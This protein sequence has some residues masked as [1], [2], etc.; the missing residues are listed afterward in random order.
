MP[1]FNWPPQTI[2][3]DRLARV[4]LVDD[5]E[6]DLKLTEMWLLRDRVDLVLHTYSSP[7]TALRDLAG[8]TF[9]RLPDIMMID[10]NMPEMMGL[11]L[12]RA[13]RHTNLLPHAAIGIATGS[14]DPVD[15]AEAIECG[16]DFFVK[17]PINT[18]VLAG[19]CQELES[20]S[21]RT[22]PSGNLSLLF[23]PTTLGK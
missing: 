8:K 12:I 11:D 23:H 10:L 20:F 9:T 5:N 3:L 6:N 7:R 16:A 4:M 18:S 21:I 2:I 17:K 15:R 14:E 19:I 1:T 22:G 13:I